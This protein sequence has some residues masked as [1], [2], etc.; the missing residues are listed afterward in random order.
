MRLAGQDGDAVS[1]CKRAASRVKQGSLHVYV[2][3]VYRI[4]L[5]SS[6]EI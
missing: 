3:E 1:F 4:V 6:K 5:I 2:T